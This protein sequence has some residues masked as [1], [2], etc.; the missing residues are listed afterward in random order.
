MAGLS[1]VG[2]R[3]R[4]VDSIRLRRRADHRW[5]QDHPVLRLASLVPLPYRDPDLG[6]D[7][8]DGHLVSGATFRRIGGVLAY[9]LT[10]N[11]KTVTTDHVAGIAIR[12]P[13]IVEV[14]RHHG[15]TKRTYLPADH[16]TKG[17]SEATVRI[18]KANLVP[19]DVNLRE[20]YKT[21]ARWRRPAARF[22]TRSPP[23][24]TG[25]LG[26]SRPSGSPRKPASPSRHPTPRG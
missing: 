6:Q 15:T 11:E 17:G 10:D 9:V 8:A 23:A 24:L 3:A 5:P 21:S 7:T 2:D 4:T 22:A 19:K 26:A 1:A 18:A 20:R 14:A 16:E 13:E 25:R 12:N